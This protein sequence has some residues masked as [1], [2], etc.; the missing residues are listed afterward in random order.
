M[1][2]ALKQ[3]TYNPMTGEVTI[4]F[5]AD[6]TAD[7]VEFSCM[8]LLTKGQNRFMKVPVYQR[9]G[10][11]FIIVAYQGDQTVTLEFQPRVAYPTIEVSPP[12]NPD[13][14]APTSAFVIPANATAQ[15]VIEVFKTSTD[16]AFQA[17]GMDVQAL[18]SA[19]L[20]TDPNANLA[21]GHYV[22]KATSDWTLANSD[23]TGTP[24]VYAIWVV[25]SPIGQIPAA[26]DTELRADPGY[27][28]HF[29]FQ[30]VQ[31]WRQIGQ[32]SDD[33]L[34]SFLHD[35]LADITYVEVAPFCHR[36]MAPFFGWSVFRPLVDL[37]QYAPKS[38]IAE[39]AKTAF[40]NDIGNRN[41]SL[42]GF[43][44]PF[45]MAAGYYKIGA[46]GN[47]GTEGLVN[48]CVSIKLRTGKFGNSNKYME[49]IWIVGAEPNAAPMHVSYDLKETPNG[50]PERFLHLRLL[51]N[52]T[53]NQVDAYLYMPSST[54]PGA[55]LDVDGN[56]SAAIDKSLLYSASAPGNTVVV[57]DSSTDT[58]RS[59]MG[60]DGIMRYRMGLTV[61]S[62]TPNPNASVD[63]SNAD[64]PLLPPKMTAA[65]KT[66]LTMDASMQGALITQIDGTLGTYRYNGSAWE[67]L[68]TV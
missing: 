14:L 35:G 7:V 34:A 29:N 67:R 5:L 68:A 40:K 11:T 16:K 4:N 37:S 30:A 58:A 42:I 22:F 52:T 6:A 31:I 66:A 36:T 20:I 15:Q 45:Y 54:W 41:G 28:E 62:L 47:M 63:F 56:F 48:S 10:Y 55:I 50:S 51:K 57:Y 60:T 46:I 61:G 25:S 24:G 17:I 38:A 49:Q 26:L 39:L 8:G 59:Q 13:A 3:P 19:A 32:L 33:L 21:T 64:K 18:H 44:L 43:V 12:L 27:D 53:T 1:A 2:L 9:E 23:F 65:K